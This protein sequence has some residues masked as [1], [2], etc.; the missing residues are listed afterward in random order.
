M[1]LKE[2]INMEC[3]DKYNFELENR[4]LA[5]EEL[6]S[7]SRYFVYKANCDNARKSCYEKGKEYAENVHKKYGNIPDSDG[8]LGNN[9]ND[10][11][12]LPRYIYRALWGWNDE[13]DNKLE[14]FGQVSNKKFENM[15][16]ETMNSA[17]TTVNK[18]IE[19]AFNRCKDE[20]IK[21]LKPEKH[22]ISRNFMLELF[23][24]N[25]SSK[26]LREWLDDVNGLS[27]FLDLYNTVG[28]FVLVP[29]YFN[30][31]RGRKPVKDFW[32]KSLM[33][34]NTKK[35]K[36]YYK[37]NEI[38]W[39]K[40]L[41]TR[42]INTFFLWEYVE[43]NK[44]REISYSDN[45]N[46]KDNIEVFLSETCRL[47]KL[48]GIFMVAMLRIIELDSCYYQDLVKNIFDTD[49]VYNGYMEVI[50]AIKREPCCSNSEVNMII[51]QLKQ[52]LSVLLS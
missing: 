15:G 35:E 43:N 29:A 11:C 34:L 20:K 39:N 48:R 42:Y 21:S 30:P 2:F 31:Y 24:N 22:K 46:I 51:D 17:Q 40:E 52:S 49:T 8:T 13:E 7:Y 41:F 12:M 18:I 23:S 9:K 14:R 44:P 5:S 26:F 37:N 10:I 27:E 4:I 36:W 1:L 6:D 28:N 50:E 47:I 16:P 45:T 3:P 32:D 25:Y 19:D 33:L 38:H